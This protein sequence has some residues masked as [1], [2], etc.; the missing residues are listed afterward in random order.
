MLWIQNVLVRSGS[1]RLGPDPNLS[2]KK[3]DKQFIRAGSETQTQKL[4]PDQDKNRLDLQNWSKCVHQSEQKPTSRLV[5]FYLSMHY[6]IFYFKKPQ[7]KDALRLNFLT[8][9][10]DF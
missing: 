2:G 4:D 1:R 7:R 10:K 3:I 9:N 6:L 8:S 5:F